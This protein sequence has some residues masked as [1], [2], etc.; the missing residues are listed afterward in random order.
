MNTSIAISDESF[1][2][3]VLKSDQP[4]LVDIWAEWCGP[5][6]RI[7]PILE[8]IAGEYSGQLVIA[9]LDTE[10]HQDKMLNY[11]VMGLPTL[12]LFKNG[13]PVERVTGMINK[14]KLLSMLLPHLNGESV[15]GT[16]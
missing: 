4:V 7:A 6:K 3:E 1:D 10:A 11:G 14:D 9:R 13:E 5:C 12:I 2:A 8:E 15:R 16:N